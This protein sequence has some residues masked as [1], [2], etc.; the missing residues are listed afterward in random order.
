[1]NNAYV[2]KKAISTLEILEIFN[3]L[4]LKLEMKLANGRIFLLKDLQI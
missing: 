4:G 2:I 3:Y 1:M